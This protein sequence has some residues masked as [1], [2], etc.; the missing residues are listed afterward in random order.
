MAIFTFYHWKYGVYDQFSNVTREMYLLS[1]SS[2][3]RLYWHSI[4][5]P[6]SGIPSNAET[7]WSL[8]TPTHAQLF[9][10]IRR[11]MLF[12]EFSNNVYHIY[13]IDDRVKVSARV[14]HIFSHIRTLW[15]L[16][17]CHVWRF[18]SHVSALSA[19]VAVLVTL[20]MHRL[21]ARRWRNIELLIDVCVLNIRSWMSPLRRS[22]N[23]VLNWEPSGLD[24]DCSLQRGDRTVQEFYVDCIT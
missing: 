6:V 3:V 9:M 21:C 10:N 7:L 15:G 13:D 8:K 5:H 14:A 17:L 24:L 4:S 16:Q 11:G 23:C 22:L 2:Q 18:N 12:P 19:S 1:S 20:A